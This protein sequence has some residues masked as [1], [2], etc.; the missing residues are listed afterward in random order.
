MAEKKHPNGAKEAII[1]AYTDSL[2]YWAYC[3]RDGSC[4]DL[5]ARNIADLLEDE[6][7]KVRSKGLHGVTGS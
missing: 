1:K 6:A 4:E 3:F 5:F 7:R 2:E